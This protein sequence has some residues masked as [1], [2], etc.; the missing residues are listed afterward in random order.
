M[1]ING[2][3]FVALITLLSCQSKTS[4]AELSAAEKETAKKE[5]A[6]RIEEIVAGVKKLDMQTA[7]K[8]YSDS[9][10]F[11]LV[12]PDARITDHAAMVAEQSEFVKQAISASYTTVKEDFKF[13]SGNF[14]MCT[15]TGKNEFTLKNG[16]RY[17]TNPYVGS[18]LFNKVGGEWK[19]VYAHES[20]AQPV[21]Q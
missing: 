5:I 11:R 16:E 8:P 7:L 1:K 9:P 18:M 3:I 2:T 12:T 6:A 4:P 10:E 20:S 13:L 14:V 17:K 21:K 15:W 19:I